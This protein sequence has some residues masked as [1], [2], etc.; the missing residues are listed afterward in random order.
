MRIE[1]HIE[2]LVLD[3][4]DLSA[5]DQERLRTATEAELTR[6]LSG[7]AGQPSRP[8]RLAATD[9]PGDT[10]QPLARRIAH[11][12]RDEIRDRHE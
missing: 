8:A 3:G 5:R 4:F 11:G 1:V 2:R 12:V 7:G 9:A 6:L 10:V